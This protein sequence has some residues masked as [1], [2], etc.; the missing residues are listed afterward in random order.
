MFGL[1]EHGCYIYIMIKDKNIIE[2]LEDLELMFKNCGNGIEFSFMG[3][4]GGKNCFRIYRDYKIGS[5][6]NWV[7]CKKILNK[8]NIDFMEGHSGW[9]MMMS[10]NINICFNK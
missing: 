10:R 9:G 5:R 2:K 4:F 8:N 6:V 7:K 1:T 3:E